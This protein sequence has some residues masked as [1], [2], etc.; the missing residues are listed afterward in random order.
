MAST[1]E[2]LSLDT[3]QVTISSG[4][5]EIR[6]SLRAPDPASPSG[7]GGPL[8]VLAFCGFAWGLALAIVGR[9]LFF[10]PAGPGWAV[11]LGW[12]FT[13]QMAVHLPLTGLSLWR[14]WTWR[15]LGR[16]DYVFTPDRVVICDDDQVWALCLA[17]EL[18]GLQV[19]IY[20]DTAP[21]GH[22]AAPEPLADLVLIVGDERLNF[23]RYVGFPAADVRALAEELHRRLGPFRAEH[24]LPPLEPLAV[25]ETTGPEAEASWG[26][27]RHSRPGRSAGDFFKRC[28]RAGLLSMTQY[29]WLATVWGLGVFAGAAG[30]YRLL[31]GA[32]GGREAVLLATFIYAVLL[33][34][35]WMAFRLERA[36]ARE[37]GRRTGESSTAPQ[38]PSPKS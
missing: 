22:E 35:V 14:Y 34:A 27:N 5:G 31:P 10:G 30:A 8:G 17:R 36:M 12:L 32:G 15:R 2:A 20:P 24:G 18:R 25:I 11:A 9:V 29:P 37:L 26:A 28:G 1:A 33:A 23:A 19:F 4:P 7:L 21:D 13:A 6:Y 3:W 38:A 16:T